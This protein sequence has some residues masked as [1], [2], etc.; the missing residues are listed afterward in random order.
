[1]DLL[2]ESLGKVTEKELFQE[3]GAFD[4]VS[5]IL[6]DGPLRGRN[7]GGGFNPQMNQFNNPGFDKN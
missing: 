6:N 2:G 3:N 4:I 1:M 7:G 5:V